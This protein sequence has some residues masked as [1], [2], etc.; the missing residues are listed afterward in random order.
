MINEEVYTGNQDDYDAIREAVKKLS[1]TSQEQFETIKK[2]KWYN[3]VFDMVTFSQKGK[4]RLAEQIGTVAQAQQILIELLLRLSS[5]DT[6][7]SQIVSDSME[8]IR[9]IQEQNLYLLSKVMQL[10][11][12]TLG[13]KPDMDIAKLSNQGKQTL[14]ACLYWVSNTNGES[15]EE[16][17]KYANVIFNYLAIEDVEMDNVIAALER[18]DKDSK[19]RILACC[20]EY[21]FLKDCTDNS[22]GD[23][24]K[25]IQEFDF[26]NKTINGI[27]KQILAIY[28]MRGSEGFYTKYEVDNFITIEDVFEMDLGEEIEMTEEEDEIEI[29]DEVISSILQIKKGET[30]VYKNKQLHFRTYI[31]CEGC[32][33]MDHCII[34]YNETEARN[35]ITLAQGA[36]LTIKNSVVI[37][38]GFDTNTFI[39]GDDKNTVIFEKNTFVDCSYFIDAE[40]T[41]RFAMTQCKL[42]NCNTNFISIYVDESTSCD[43][44]NNIIRQNYLNPFYFEHK[45]KIYSG[46]LIFIRTYGTPVRFHNNIILEESKFEKARSENDLDKMCYFSCGNAEV[47]NCTFSGLS[48][49]IRVPVVKESRFDNCT[50]A[51]KTNAYGVMECLVDNCIFEMC[52]NIISMNEYTKITNCQFISCYNSLIKP[53]GY[54]GAVEIEFCQFWNTKN[55]ERYSSTSGI[56]GGGVCIGFQRTNARANRLNKCV[57]DGVELLDNFLIAA[58]GSKKPEGPVSYITECDFRNCRT[59]RSSGKIIMEFM[60]YDTLFKKEQGFR[61]NCISNCRGLDKI[62]KEGEKAEK[63]EVKSISTSGSAIGAEMPQIKTTG[64]V[65]LAGAPIAL[66]ILAGITVVYE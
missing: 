9:R 43:I 51:L 20:M 56:L 16:Q 29:T 34:Y 37:C 42:E 48:N 44:S 6:N 13:I 60:Q 63:V 23:Y 64:A 46:T 57:F 45:S 58:M 59:L 4:K 49:A 39:K 8:D 21:I 53:I 54:R 5:N 66:S 47:T 17:K 28:K 10:E 26:G 22:Y 24:D 61:A 62:S 1:S 40:S 65:Y 12:I 36:Q 15:S 11:N 38:K 3:R 32:L 19:R 41:C 7:I 27:K 2:E 18:L 30:R 55:D 31:N 50:E 25:F 14:S 52:T 33:E 35:V